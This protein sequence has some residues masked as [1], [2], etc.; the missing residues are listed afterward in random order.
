MMTNLAALN[1][2]FGLASQLVFKAG[3]GGLTTAE[4]D[5]SFAAATVVLQGGHVLSF[6]PHNQQPVLW[7]SR[8][9]YF[10][11]GKA[12]RGG[13]PVCWPWFANHP[14][15]SD[16]PAHGFAR[17]QPWRVLGSEMTPEGAT[18][19]RLGL[20]D[21]T[22][23]RALWP[24]PFQL[25]LS[26]SVGAALQV[27]LLIRNP[28]ETA[29]T[30]T[31]ALHSYFSVSDIANVTITSLEGS[32]YLDKVAD[33]QRRE[34]TGPITITGETDRVYLDTSA[35]CVIIDP[36]WQRQ[37]RVAKQ[38][39]RTTVV[40]NPWAEKA[41]QMADFGAEEYRQMVCV[42]TANAADDV[43][44]VPAGPEHRLQTTISLEPK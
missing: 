17:T 35:D 30:C 41:R 13:I 8:D 37:I 26:V 44:T 33:N 31:G 11:I 40:W 27:E 22:A 25:E 43:I 9:S 36:G 29:F 38:G 14:T 24:H 6:Q 28:G 7:V 19:L 34:Q 39:S 16:K 12:I 42:E 2:Q 10:T 18:R 1:E 21:T 4:I 32:A 5:N 15:E 23:T 20:T 3:P